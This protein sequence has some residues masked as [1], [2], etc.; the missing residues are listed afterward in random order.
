[1][2][3]GRG[4]TRVH[5]PAIRVPM[6]ISHRSTHRVAPFVVRWIAAFVAVIAATLALAPAGALADGSPNISLANDAQDT[7]LYGAESSVRLTTTNPAGSSGTAYNLSYRVVVPTNV[8]YVAGSAGTAGEPVAIANQPAAGQ[9]TLLWKNVADVGTGSTH[10]LD[11]RVQHAVL[12]YV[13]GSVYTVSANAY[14]GSNDAYPPGFTATGAPETTGP[15]AY[16]GF[17]TNVNDTTTIKALEI[18]KT[19]D[20]PSPTELLRGIHGQQAIYTVAVKNTSMA[21]TTHLVVEDYLPAGLEFIG[22]CGAVGADHTTNAPSNPG[23]NQ[24]YPG[25][26]AIPVG[27]VP[28][29]IA[30]NEVATLTTDPTGPAPNAL[31]TRVRWTALGTIAPGATVTLKYRAAVPL[32]GNTLTWTAGT[33]ATTGAQAANLDNNSGGEVLDGTAITNWSRAQGDFNDT[34]FTQAD[35]GVTRTVKDVIV[36]KAA[37]A[38]ATLQRGVENLWDLTVRTSEY[39]S[40][41]NTIVTDTVPD[42]LCPLSMSANFTQTPQDPS[43]TADCFTGPDPSVPYATVQENASGTFTVVWNS[44][45]L[46]ALAELGPNASQTITFAT[47]ARQS[48][49]ENFADAA[50][51]V[52]LDTVRNDV[53]VGATARVICNGAVICPAG[54]ATGN[55]ISHSG[56]LSA[57]VTDTASDTIRAAGPVIDKKVADTSTDCTAAT[58]TDGG[59]APIYH[60][61]DRICW[62]LRIDYPAGSSTSAATITDY[63]PNTL[64]FDT[65]FGT[66]GEQPT[67]NDTAGA[68]TFD[69]TAATPGPGGAVQWTLASP[70]VGPSA[71]FEHRMA[72]RV[73]LATGAA[74]GDVATNVGSTT[75][76][77]SNG[78]TTLRD[79]ASYRLA[80][81]VLATQKR[82]VALDGV[83]V[84]GT[85]GVTT[86]VVRGGQDVTYRVRLSNSGDQTAERVEAWDPLPAGVTCADVAATGQAISDGGVCD[87]GTI[88]WGASP[89]IGPD[90]P[91]VANKDL[92]Y[93][94]RVPTTIEPTQALTSAAGVRAFQTPTNVGGTFVYVPAGNV[95]PTQNSSA[96]VTSPTSAASVTGAI[97]TISQ[98]RTTSVVESSGGIDWNAADNAT[99]GETVRYAVSAT[100]PAGVTV[101]DFE[102]SDPI[103]PRQQYVA[104]SLTQT[105]GPTAA[106]LSI[107]GATIT[108][109]MGS[110]WTAPVGTDTTFTF[111]FETKVLDIT[112]NYRSATDLSNLATMLYT[113]PGTASGGARTS[114]STPSITTQIVEPSLTLSK[115]ADVG[116]TPVIGNDIVQYTLSLANITGVTSPA[117]ETTLVDTVPTDMTP[118]NAAGNPIAD[119]ESTLDGGVWNLAARTLT[120]SPSATIY[121]GSTEN[122]VY[123]VRVNDPAVAG[124]AITNNVTATTTSLAGTVAGERTIASPRTTGY[125]VSR[126]ST[127]NV[128]TPSIITSVADTNL[129]I[130]QRTTYT[131]DVTIPAN[132]V[133]YDATVRETLPDSLDFDGYLS[134]TCTAGCAPGPTTPTIQPYTPVINGATG[135]ISL[136]WDLGDLLTQAPVTRTFRLTF[137]AHLRATHRLGGTN[138]VRPQTSIDSVRV[139]SNRTNKIASF[140]AA[141]IP[142][143]TFDDTSPAVTRTITAVEPGFTVDKRIAI[144]ASPT[145]Y[146]N[147][148]VMVHDGDKLNYRIIVTNTGNAPAHDIEVTDLPN[149]ELRNLSPTPAAGITVTDPWATVGDDIKWTIQGPIA[150]GATAT[151][152]YTAD[153]PPVTQIKDADNFDN[154]AQVTKGWGVPVATRTADGGL[155][156]TSLSTFLYR[157][158]TSATDLTRATFDSPTIVVDKTTGSG[159][160]PIYPDSANAQV[161]APF[162]WR[163]RVTNTSTTETAT[164]LTVRDTLPKDWTY[165][166]GSASFS[167]GGSSIPTIVTNAAGDQLTWSTALSLAPGGTTVLSYQA[168]PNLASATS[169]GT[170]PGSPHRNTASATVRNGVGNAADETG[171]FVG[172]PNTADAILQV[173]TL[174]IAKTPDNGAYASGQTVP[175]H[176]VVANTGAVPATNVVVSDAFPSGLTYTPGSATASPSSGFSETTGTATAGSWTI[177]SIAAGASVDITV[178][179]KTDA[180]AP[181]GTTITN[182]ASVLSDQTSVAVS[183]N[184]SVVLTPSA[185][186]VATKT[187]SPTT[188]MAGGTLTYTIGATNNGPSDAQNVTFTDTLTNRVTYVSSS[189]GCTYN[190]GQHRVTCTSATPLAS[191]A[192]RTSTITVKIKNTVTTNA[193]NTVTVSSSTTDPQSSNNSSTV[194]VPVGSR[195]DLKLTKTASSPTVPRGQ[196][197]S[198]TLAYESLGPSDATNA[199]IVDTL[200]AGL[201]YVSGPAGCSAIGQTVTCTL[202]TLVDA[203]AGTRTIVVRGDTLGPKSNTAAISSS[204]IDPDTANN[205]SSAS[206]TVVPATDLGI[207]KSGPATVAAGADVPYVLTATNAGPDPATAVTITDTLPVGTS[208]KSGDPGCT[209][210][211]RT[212][213]CVVGP[214]PSGAV[215]TR[216][217]VASTTRSM[218][219]Q[220]ITNTASIGGA[221]GDPNPAN[222]V[223][224]A[225]TQIGPAADLSITQTAPAT[226]PGGGQATFSIIA[227]NGGP[228]TATGVKV[229]S[230]LPDGVTLESVTS[231]QGTCSVSGQTITCELGALPNGASADV[232]IVVRLASSLVGRELTNTAT[233]TADQPDPDGS[234]EVA[235]QTLQVVAPPVTPEPQA[236]T[237]PPAVT[238]A[239]GQKAQLSLTKTTN[240]VSR[241]GERLNYLITVTNSG[242]DVAQ[243]VTITDALTGDVTF[244][245]A[246]SSGVT[247]DF[248]RGAIGCPVGKL[249]VGD[250]VRVNVA[251]TPNKAGI[252]VN[253]AVVTSSTTDPDL[254]DNRAIAQTTS[255]APP[256][257]LQ[258][259]AKAS[260]SRLRGGQRVT[261]T[262]KV[263]NLGKAKSAKKAPV[264][265]PAVAVDVCD[266]LPSQLEFSS[267]KGGELKDARLCFHVKSMK[268]GEQKVFKFRVRVLPRAR[269]GAFTNKITAVADNAT[270]VA[271]GVRSTVTTDGKVSSS[272]VR[273]FTG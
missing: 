168:R 239:P 254:S 64:T 216:N 176:L 151:I 217:I 139:M 121:P 271:F 92:T 105:A 78:T 52:A 115:T 94:V 49:Q 227:R 142:S 228:S 66:G 157:S 126:T 47:R 205:G 234:N 120:F 27:A 202:G 9:T 43:D 230:E 164:A 5:R 192:S 69:A 272:Q 232:T 149:A 110:T 156:A 183:D 39:R 182:T 65:A 259:S 186:L 83:G 123:R 129:T 127:I 250:S 258:M 226:A 17:K 224:S 113:P 265:A 58:Y 166:A 158:Y 159:S 16:T 62:Q 136:A 22:G 95:D 173:P 255:T 206:V 180:A 130:G 160:G 179:L 79:D 122:F 38:P 48:Y 34:V 181:A 146:G 73:A 145:T 252:L 46:P 90:I 118:L 56:G 35:G 131:L 114:T 7:V 203:D 25:S 150:P 261:Y 177:A 209:A 44:T 1:M 162:T 15:N 194:L 138:V 169:I 54:P 137:G 246:K 154:T 214:L 222:D 96:N 50:P 144:G 249:A 45:S 233:V 185:D 91:Q 8:A 23:T 238:P 57:A 68:A 247:C 172:A 155:P 80:M 2:Q 200:P 42:G 41:Q 111:E 74:P 14:V 82:V 256:T 19:V 240:Q 107:S 30:P 213:T 219:D 10:V 248:S 112:T 116:T 243:G 235:G 141:S 273:G 148:P 270:R 134:Q 207:A 33:P 188:G 32:R 31:Y 70:T 124:K 97:P 267:T 171:A 89:A 100:V 104:S 193:D 211:A 215:A 204:V 135:T 244:R 132:T 170:G 223:A 98:A 196:N 85:A 260:S 103:L 71:V 106:A 125:T 11:F 191:G 201:S 67:G 262:V 81:P 87:S 119:G 3:G 53:T 29:C 251:V 18:T 266:T 40:A 257:T 152:E 184:G 165:V 99:I 101:R 242:P 55:E 174:T 117:H 59:P 161:G 236:P 143:G 263:R 167:P 153:L 189:A 109:S 72:T 86:Q 241:A 133:A 269:R 6:L 187:A 231:A 163:V 102:V 75:L 12:S 197:V 51:I 212:V 76:T 4:L 108:F 88:K 220:A 128:L 26:G 198:F 190:A 253:N 218:G 229:T 93:T 140:N 210:V 195:A 36:Q 199:Q 175:F 28:G 77:T 37:R 221:E 147:G 208:F 24:E 63:L 245:S 237:E 61:G 60:P 13:V 264:D 21:Q 225:S 20:T 178:P 84:G 268:P